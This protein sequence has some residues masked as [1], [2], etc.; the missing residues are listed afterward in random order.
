MD[1]KRLIQYCLS[2]SGRCCSVDE[3]RGVTHIAPL[4]VQLQ[5]VPHRLMSPLMSPH[6][7]PRLSRRPD[8]KE[9]SRSP[10]MICLLQRSINFLIEGDHELVPDSSVER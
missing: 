7:L 5:T 8:A 9:A 4:F 6:T 2:L 1:R 3:E 10:S